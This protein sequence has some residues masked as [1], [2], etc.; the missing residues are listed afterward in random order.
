MRDTPG[1]YVKVRAHLA[2]FGSLLLLR[3]PGDWT[4]VA[5]VGSKCFDTLSHLSSPFIICF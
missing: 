2:G 5:R 3:G 1:P 4:E